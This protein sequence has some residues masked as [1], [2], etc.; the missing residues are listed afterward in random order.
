MMM[1]V[2]HAR[3][4]ACT[5][6]MIQVLL[7]NLRPEVPEVLGPQ[8]QNLLRAMW[9]TDPAARPT[10]VHVLDTLDTAV[11]AGAAAFC[12]AARPLYETD[13]RRPGD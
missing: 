13:N 3:T 8:M 2:A 11:A 10:L 12:D 7:G 6:R 9:S 1:A 4:H 5:A